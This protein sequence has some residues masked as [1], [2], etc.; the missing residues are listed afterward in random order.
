MINGGVDVFGFVP[1]RLHPT[2]K[3]IIKIDKNISPDFIL[4][5][6]KLFVYIISLFKNITSL[7]L[8]RFLAADFFSLPL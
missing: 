6:V 4:F 2:A 7:N 1:L 3:L 8:I 5:R